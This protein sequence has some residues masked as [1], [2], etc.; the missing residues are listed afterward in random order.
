MP[1]ELDGIMAIK[2][3]KELGKNVGTMTPDEEYIINNL[4]PKAGLLKSG[5]K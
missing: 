5:M 4:Q 2:T 3:F 1:S